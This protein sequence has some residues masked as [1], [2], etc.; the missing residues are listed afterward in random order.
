MTVTLI[1]F[2]CPHCHHGL[3]VAAE[4]G[5]RHERCPA[6]GHML[7]VPALQ[8]AAA[9]PLPPTPAPRPVVPAQAIARLGPPAASRATTTDGCAPGQ[10]P[11]AIGAKAILFGLG[12]ALT[13]AAAVA[14]TVVLLPRSAGPRDAG[15]LAPVTAK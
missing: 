14:V 11:R 10:P 12:L 9:T 2:A 3:K 1:H 7:E 13:L 15:P 8:H 6:C 4:A 5:G